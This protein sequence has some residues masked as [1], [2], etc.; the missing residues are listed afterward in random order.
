MQSVILYWQV[1]SLTEKETDSTRAFMIGFIGLSEFIPFFI[2]SFFSGQVADKY[3]RKIITSTTIFLMLLQVL[4][5]FY[6]SHDNSFLLKTNG[7]LPLYFAVIFWGIIRA[8]MGPAMQSFMPQIL[9]RHLY[10]N[11]ATWNSTVWHIAAIVGPSIGGLLCGFL[12]FEKV[13]LIDTGIMTIGFFFFIAIKHV[14]K[15]A[16][17]MKEGIIESLAT[18]TKF[19]FA[20]KILLGALSLDL[21]AVLF[22]GATAML[23]AFADK[24]LHVGAIELGFLRAAPAIGAVIVAIILAYYPP[25]KNSGKKL[26]LSVA[27]FGFFTIIF[28]LSTNFYLTIFLLAL[29]GAFDNISVV[30]RHTILQLMTPDNMRG[31]VSAVN[32]IFIGSSNEIGAFESGVAAGLMGLVPS[33]IFGG[34]MTVVIVITIALLSKPLLKL[35]M[36]NIK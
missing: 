6:L 17:E 2:F 20:N 4:L 12:S 11:G 29:I 35:H 9:P 34:G 7:I 21:F 1:Y 36:N 5:L 19:V 15:P 10:G 26:L 25:V 14:H 27:A 31:R 28:A 13:Y 24:I 33:V 30:I 3:N 16:G 22:G 23:P 18:G 32:G 8:F